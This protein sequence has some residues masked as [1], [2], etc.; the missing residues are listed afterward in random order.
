MPPFCD[1]AVA[2]ADAGTAADLLV[3]AAA[4]GADDDADLVAA[5]GTTADLAAGSA[6]LRASSAFSASASA[7]A[8]NG[9]Q[10]EVH[11]ARSVHSHMHA[12][13]C[14]TCRLMCVCCVCEL[15]T[16]RCER[17]HLQPSHN[18]S[19]LALHVHMQTGGAE[20]HSFRAHGTDDRLWLCLFGTL[21]FACAFGCANY[22]LIHIAYHK[23]SSDHNLFKPSSLHIIS[24]HSKTRMT[25]GVDTDDDSPE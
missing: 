10:C 4:A 12:F 24:V 7:W 25:G 1:D 14:T 11:E 17:H 16:S 9:L 15:M 6:A 22:C 8:S 20:A 2:D 13:L 21:W 5:D 23:Q 18:H 19:L 3:A